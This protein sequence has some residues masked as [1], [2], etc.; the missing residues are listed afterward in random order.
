MIYL[1]ISIL[2]AIIAGGAKAIQDICSESSF[3]Q[4]K[5]FIK[6]NFKDSF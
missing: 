5:L 1:I 6:Y 2:L 4:S 3:Y